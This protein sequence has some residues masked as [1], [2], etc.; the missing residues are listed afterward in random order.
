MK[1]LNTLKIAWLP[2]GPEEIKR[3]RI[4]WCYIDIE[5]KILTRER[6]GERMD[7][8]DKITSQIHNIT[9]VR[10]SEENSQISSMHSKLIVNNKD[11]F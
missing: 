2:I 11:E 1:S 5:S 9:R 6:F 7:F 10:N 4:K 8:W 3:K